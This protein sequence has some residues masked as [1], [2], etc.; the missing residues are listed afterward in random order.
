MSTLEDFERALSQVL[1]TTELRRLVLTPQQ[2]D[3]LRQ[4]VLE[5]I[6]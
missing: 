5:E 3:A 2:R 4:L 6:C 1:A